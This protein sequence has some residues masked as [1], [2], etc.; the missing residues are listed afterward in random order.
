MSEGETGDLCSAAADRH[1]AQHGVTAQRRPLARRSWTKMPH[2]VAT[3][4]VKLGGVRKSSRSCTLGSSSAINP[5]QSER[6]H[7]SFLL[8]ITAFETVW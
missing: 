1:A 8:H 4:V 5:K 3:R 7:P 6:V 2:S